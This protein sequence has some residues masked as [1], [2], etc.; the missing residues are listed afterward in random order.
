MV[1]FGV[2]FIYFCISWRFGRGGGWVLLVIYHWGWVIFHV[3]YVTLGCFGKGVGGGRVE[4]E[5]M[6]ERKGEI[7]Y[8]SYF[9]RSSFDYSC[10][11][12]LVLCCVVLCACALLGLLLRY[13]VVTMWL[14]ISLSLSRRLFGRALCDKAPDCRPCNLALQVY[15]CRS[16]MCSMHLQRAH[17]YRRHTRW[18]Q[19]ACS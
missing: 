7:E 10:G 8:M 12:M 6:R 13:V 3:V 19:V 1:F 4:M 14:R 15:N 17:G 5:R 18:A 11:W 16:P 9:T 2:F